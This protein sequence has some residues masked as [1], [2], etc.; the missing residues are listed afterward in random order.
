MTVSQHSEEGFITSETVLSFVIFWDSAE[1]EQWRSCFLKTI[2][3]FGSTLCDL[4]TLAPSGMFSLDDI[5]W[6]S[7]F[8]R[9]KIVN[10]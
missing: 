4:I 5:G 9:E 2:T 8:Q 7:L 6:N 3:D 10:Y 1:M